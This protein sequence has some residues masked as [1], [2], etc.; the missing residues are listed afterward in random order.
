MSY[1]IFIWIISRCFPH[2]KSVTKNYYYYSLCYINYLYTFFYLLFRSNE[3]SHLVN[4]VRYTWCS[5]HHSIIIIIKQN[6]NNEWNDEH[7]TIKRSSNRINFSLLFDFRFVYVEQLNSLCIWC[8]CFL[9]N[10]SQ[11]I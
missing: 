6:D 2:H 10:M 1:S 7:R 9:F 8:N 3:T 4:G 5:I 11:L